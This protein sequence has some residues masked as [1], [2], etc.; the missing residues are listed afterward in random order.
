LTHVPRQAVEDNPNPFAGLPTGQEALQDPRRQRKLF[1]L[2]Q[3][4][5]LQHVA[6]EI[7]VLAR[8]NLVRFVSR[9]GLPQVL[10]KIKVHAS[11]A[12]PSADC[13]Q[14][15]QGRFSRSGWPQQEQ[16]R[17]AGVTHN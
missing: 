13:Q 15:A 12:G 14:F 2:Q 4:P 6:Q 1:V 8:E 9:H 10:A 3:G 5:R 11:L 16:R 17:W 7:E